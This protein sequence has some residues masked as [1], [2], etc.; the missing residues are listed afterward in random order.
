MDK[1]KITILVP[2]SMSKRLDAARLRAGFPNI[3][4]FITFVL[5]QIFPEEVE[6]KNL[7][8]K[9]LIEKKLRDLGYM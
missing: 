3:A 5:N 7:K 2:A 6:E 1:K 9:D 4:D 8:E